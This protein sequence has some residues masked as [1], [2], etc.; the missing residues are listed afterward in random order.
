M[1]RSLI[2]IAL[3]IG[4][5]TPSSS[6]GADPS[7]SSA[8]QVLD[9]SAEQ[10]KYTFLLFYREDNQ[11]TRV[12]AQTLKSGIAKRADR[13]SICFVSV[14]DPA[15]QAVVKRFGVT[16]APLPFAL[17]VA[18]NGAITGLFSQKLVE[19][20]LDG[21]F[22]TPRM[23]ECMKSMQDKKLVL[24]C[25][26]ASDRG[27]TPTA[28]KEFQ[29]DPEFKDRVA[30]I[31]VQANDPTETQFLKQMEIVPAQ[32][33]T[34]TIVFLAPPAVLVGKF[35]ATATKAEMAAALHKAGQC[36]DDPNCKHAHGPQATKNSST[37]RN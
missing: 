36:C 19:A 5:F 23:A 9:K 25:V 16:R 15:E 33:K 32:T 34:S 6:R 30:V 26:H 21:A 28:V 27:V 11:A 35:G 24:V 7:A 22:V 4:G 17:A 10:Q 12:M 2:A 20:N 3:V 14:T 31:S 1:Y 37:K 18:P 13:A 29:A 8:Q